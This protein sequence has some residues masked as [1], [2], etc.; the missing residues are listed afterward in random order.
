M[1][2]YKAAKKFIP[3][4]QEFNSKNQLI[5]IADDDYYYPKHHIETLVRYF[6]DLNKDSRIKKAVGTT[7]YR[8]NPDKTWGA[9]L[10]S[11]SWFTFS[12]FSYH[13]VRG[14]RIRQPYR[15]SVVTGSG[16]VAFNS[17]WFQNTNIS[18]FRG[19]PANAPLM[20]D[21][22]LNGH[23]TR[24]GVEKYVIPLQDAPIPVLKNSVIDGKLSENSV[25]NVGNN[26][27]NRFLANNQMISFFD[28]EFTREG[29]WFYPN[30]VDSPVYINYFY[31]GVIE[32]IKLYFAKLYLAT[33]FQAFH[34]T[35]S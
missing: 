35:Q 25:D 16:C 30:G 12:D 21:I 22:W 31:I 14:F 20:D 11:N 17:K 10:Y 33:L 7:G 24:L 23:F 27:E 34:L 1:P 18:D 26:N 28:T 6:V 19:A 2:D 13:F 9:L 4:I 32:P 5:I 29:L 3:S 15:V 8:L